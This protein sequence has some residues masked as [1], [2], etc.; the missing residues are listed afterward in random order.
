MVRW[1]AGDI[2]GTLELELVYYNL[3]RFVAKDGCRGS[4]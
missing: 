1:D 2:E 3:G 4:K